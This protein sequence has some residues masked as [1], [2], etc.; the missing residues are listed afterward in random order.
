MILFSRLKEKT[1]RAS[2]NLQ[3]AHQ[4]RYCLTSTFC[5]VIA[6]HVNLT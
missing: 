6:T 4:W 2:L 5:C 1:G 3:I